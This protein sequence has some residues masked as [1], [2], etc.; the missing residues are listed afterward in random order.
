MEGVGTSIDFSKSYVR[1]GQGG[2]T[3]GEKGAPKWGIK[4][5]G[6]GS[7]CLDCRS[8]S[9]TGGALRCEALDD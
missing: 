9:L 6:G 3:E 5:Q 4:E 7:A 8:D 1:E 2:G